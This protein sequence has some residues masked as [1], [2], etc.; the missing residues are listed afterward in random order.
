[1][2]RAILDGTK[3]QTRRV[4]KPQP[5]PELLA[6]YAE[7]RATRGSAFTDAQMLSDCLPCPYGQP[8]DRLWVRET[9]KPHSSF[10]GMKPRDMPESEVFYRADD[11]YAPSPSQ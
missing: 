8:G 6:D 5:S 1:M 4:V 11:A 7:I 10:A 2:V 9:W 3:T